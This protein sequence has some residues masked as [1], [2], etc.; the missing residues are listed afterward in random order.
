MNGF[1]SLSSAALLVLAF[2]AVLPAQEGAGRRRGGRVGGAAQASTSEPTFWLSV[3]TGILLL[4]PVWDG[5]SQS[6]WDFGDG[7]PL[8]FAVEREFGSGLSAGLAGSYTRAP[9][10]YSGTGS[11]SACDGS[12]RCNAHAT[13]ATYGAVFR[14]GGTS[15]QTGMY[16][17]FRLFLGAIQYGAFEQDSPRRKLPPGGANKDLLFSAGYGFGYA[18]TGDWRLEL[19]GE[20]MNGV[21][22]RDNLPGN[23]QTLARHYS[24]GLGLRVGL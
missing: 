5:N 12:I 10:V 7:F 23:V 19:T 1:R 22:E 20:Y 17:F 15:G 8:T 9:L 21:H 2:A 3:G 18:F 4:A 11:N 24:I 14:G 6:L 13:V 16:Q